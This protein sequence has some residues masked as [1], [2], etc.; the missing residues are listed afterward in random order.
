MKQK[1]T[2]AV[3]SQSN[4]QMVDRIRG[5]SAAL[6]KEIVTLNQAAYPE[7]MS[8]IEGMADGA[9]VSLD[10]LLT[11]NLA[12]ILY[13]LLPTNGS[14]P[15]A[16][17]PKQCTDV[18]AITKDFQGWAH[19]EDE[20]PSL[21]YYLVLSNITTA[22]TSEQYV[23]FAYAGTVAGW[24]WG[25]NHMGHAQSINAIPLAPKATTMGKVRVITF[26]EPNTLHLSTLT[27]FFST[28][29]LALRG[30]TS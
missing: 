27:C 12:D 15:L 1:I 25:F 3:S 22:T 13:G 26:V 9:G 28:G 4:Q 10:A 7:V 8:E 21:G 5:G 17:R 19:N 18:H 2:A 24:A 29:F 16:W 6:F 23:A 14:Y 11:I 20:S 30:S